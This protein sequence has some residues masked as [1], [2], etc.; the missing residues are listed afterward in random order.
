MC[1]RLNF[2]AFGCVEEAKFWKS[3]S[4]GCHPRAVLAQR[5]DLGQTS[6]LTSLHLSFH[7]F[8]KG[9]GNITH[10]TQY[11][12]CYIVEMA[13]LRKHKGFSHVRDDS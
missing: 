4:L 5:G 11:K 12:H 6:C 7:G 8:Q 10:L 2:G 1:K 3:W 13:V 9:T